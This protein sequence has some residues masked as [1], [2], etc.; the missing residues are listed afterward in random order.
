MSSHARK[1]TNPAAATHPS[2]TI[3]LELNQSSSLPLSSMI[4]S[5]ATHTT[6][7]TRPVTST[8]TLRVGVSRER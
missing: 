7:S 4:C 1:V 6:S 5:D 2:S 8:G 3:S